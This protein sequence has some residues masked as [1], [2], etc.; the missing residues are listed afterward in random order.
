MPCLIGSQ[1]PKP[2]VTM[3]IRS[4]TPCTRS[5][6]ALASK[7]VVVSCQALAEGEPG[8]AFVVR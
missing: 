3:S 8:G 6:S 2:P 5:P 7:F 4:S 1:L